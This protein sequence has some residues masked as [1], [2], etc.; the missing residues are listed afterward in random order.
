MIDYKIIK[1]HVVFIL[2]IHILALSYVYAC[3]L[4][5]V[6]LSQWIEDLR[7]SLILIFSSRTSW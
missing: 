5:Y 3:I 1:N 6:F 4:T 2:L 7:E